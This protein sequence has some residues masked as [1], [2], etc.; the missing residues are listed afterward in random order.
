MIALRGAS[1]DQWAV[2][3]T[4]SSRTLPYWAQSSDGEAG[5]EAR[6]VTRALVTLTRDPELSDPVPEERT[7][8]LPD[9]GEGDTEYLEIFS[10]E[11]F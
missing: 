9:R 11:E 5:S 8:E 3:L 2:P 4:I 10:S 6:H 7:G 1:G